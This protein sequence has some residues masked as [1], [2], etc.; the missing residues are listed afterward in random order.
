MEAP[1]STPAVQ[2]RRWGILGVLIISLLVVVLDTTVLNVALRTI[3][4]PRH[5]LDA[6]QSQLEWMINS[7]TLVFAGLLFTAGIMADRMGRRITLIAGLATF[8]LASLASAYAGSPEHLIATRAVMGLGA[9]AVMP[10]TLS[11]IANV[12]DA[13]E[14]GRAIGVWAAAAG[15]GVAIGPIVGGLLLERFWWGSVFLINVP[16]VVLGIVLVAVLVPESRAP[17][18]GRLDVVGVLL[19][20]AGL[21]L[22]TYGVIKGGEDGFDTPSAWGSLVAATVVLTGFVALQRRLDSPSLD[23]RLFTN[24]VFSASTGA[25]GLVFFAAMGTL[26]LAAFYLQLVRGYGPLASGALYL[27]FAIGQIALAPR[28]AAMVKRFGPKAVSTAGLLLVAVSQAVWLVVGTA[29][30]IWVVGMAFFICGAGMAHVIPPATEMIMSALP[31]EKAGV[32]SSVNNTMRQLGG[33]LGVS[34]LGAVVASVYRG[35]IG[36]ATD[37]LPTTA[38][39]VARHDISGAYAVAQQSDTNGTQLIAHA[40]DAF[41]AAMHYAALGATIVCLLGALTTALWL[42]A[43]RPVSGP[44]TTI[45]EA[46]AEKHGSTVA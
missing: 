34:T 26:F 35:R 19:S 22:L 39:E 45:D 27:P 2:P 7:Y 36:E 16:L 33:A 38:A 8:G 30:P 37:G 14:R 12:F 21:T 3:A 29:T 31:P 24:R 20:V 23:V 43:R 15:L 11:I 13:R 28:S 25:I 42:P 1:F 5:G 18:S 44:A 46:L 40:N 9:A 41:V 32:G 6:T 4:D 17:R 10:A